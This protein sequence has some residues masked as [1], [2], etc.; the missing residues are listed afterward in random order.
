MWVT[1]SRS[2]LSPGGVLSCTSISSILALVPPPPEFITNY[3]N[4]HAVYAGLL[5]GALLSVSCRLGSYFRL[6]LPQNIQVVLTAF[7]V[8]LCQ[9][10][11]MW[12]LSCKAIFTPD[13]YGIH[14]GFPATA[15]CLPAKVCL[16][17]PSHTDTGRH[18]PI[19]DLDR[20]LVPIYSIG[21]RGG[22]P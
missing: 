4:M 10:L 18:S 15:Q 19:F 12:V 8:R 13:A 7:L 6:P 2:I 22:S 11:L 9:L 3:T 1:S 5:L 20:G 16:H 21:E 17:N 14:A